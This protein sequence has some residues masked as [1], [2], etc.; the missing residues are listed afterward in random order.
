MLVVFAP[1][2]LGGRTWSDLTYHVDVAPP[3]LAAA[4]T[5]QSG[6]LPTWWN[7]TALGGPRLAEPSHGAAYPLV[8]LATTPQL[9]D[10]LWVA[11]LL[12]CALGV[13]LW[14][15][16]LRASELGAVVA[17]VLVATSGIMMSAALRGA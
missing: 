17:G 2:V 10:L 8:W 11:H 1:I 7:G 4:E 15:R 5:V 16:R 12:W 13:A 3:R 9:L 6:E 14:A